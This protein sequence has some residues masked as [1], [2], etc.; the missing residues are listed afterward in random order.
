MPEGRPAIPA[1]LQRALLEETGHRCAIPT[2]GATE[3]LEFAHIEP[4]AT[5]QEHSFENLIVLCANDHY[6]FD[7]GV[8]TRIS[9]QN[10]KAN[11]ALLHG[12][13]SDV[14]R[15]VLQMFLL[16]ADVHKLD[17][18]PMMTVAGGLR[19]LFYA[20]VKD[21]VVDLHPVTGISMNGIP[22]HDV[23]VLT[24]KGAKIVDRMRDAELIGDA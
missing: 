3:A 1:A 9:M 7:R 14:E 11:L 24:A 6:R 16:N 13:Y 15:R 10:Y 4:W 17:D 23:L 18:A 5:V 19:F 2:C 22:S 20:L 21:G 12:R 8:I